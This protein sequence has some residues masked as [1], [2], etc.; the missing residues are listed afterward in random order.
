[1][2]NANQV[3]FVCKQYTILSTFKR[4]QRRYYDKARKLGIFE[5]ATKHMIRG[6]KCPQ[7]II[8]DEKPKFGVCLLQD[9]WVTKGE[10]AED[11]I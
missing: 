10:W 8:E 4:Y 1:M 3:M 2:L 9:Y 7:E 5:E 6:V 11:E